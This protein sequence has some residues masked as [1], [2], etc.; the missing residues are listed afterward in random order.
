MVLHIFKEFG[1]FGCEW[2]DAEGANIQDP[3]NF[4]SNLGKHTTKESIELTT[5]AFKMAKEHLLKIDEWCCAG[6]KDPSKAMWSI[7]KGGGKQ[8][9]MWPEHLLMQGGNQSGA[10]PDVQNCR[11]SLEALTFL[12]G[13]SHGTENDDVP[14]DKSSPASSAAS[15]PAASSGHFDT[16]DFLCPLCFKSVRKLNKQVQHIKERHSFV[17][18][19][20]SRSIGLTIDAGIG[21]AEEIG[22]GTLGLCKDQ[23]GGPGPAQHLN[24]DSICGIFII[25][26]RLFSA[27]CAASFTSDLPPSPQLKLPLSTQASEEVKGDDTNDD[28]NGT[29]KGRCLLQGSKKPNLRI[30]AKRRLSFDRGSNSSGGS[31]PRSPRSPRSPSTPLIPL[32]PKSLNI[33]LKTVNH[34]CRL[35]GYPGML[36]YSHFWGLNS[37]EVMLQRSSGRFDAAG[38]NDDW[39]ESSSIGTLGTVDDLFESFP[40]LMEVPRKTQNFIEMRDSSAT[41]Y[42]ITDNSNRSSGA[43]GDCNDAKNA[44]TSN[45]NKT[46]SSKQKAAAQGSSR[47]GKHNSANEQSLA[48]SEKYPD[49][50]KC[51]ENP[52]STTSIDMSFEDYE[53]RKGSVGGSESERENGSNNEEE[54]NY[55]N[56]SIRARLIEEAFH[57]IVD[58]SLKK[59]PNAKKEKKGGGRK[60][61]TSKSS[62]GFYDGKKRIMWVVNIGDSTYNITLEHGVLSGKKTLSINGN[63]LAVKG[64]KLFDFGG[65]FK[66]RISDVSMVVSVE[67]RMSGVFKYKLMI[68]GIKDPILTSKL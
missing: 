6:K 55:R 59:D 27:H 40:F 43:G 47:R 46:K 58:P 45:K 64:K 9:F 38:I 37:S 15:S 50:V 54:L 53:S 68:E 13:P 42:L 11:E 39:T 51:V 18:S 48:K 3:V 62:W 2:S 31:S 4:S 28:K 26:K 22:G 10:N 57:K 30:D 56:K 52:M 20:F 25:T 16:H 29:L 66:F 41:P 44:V 35:A 67:S 23:K 19:F 1:N 5:E 61:S 17:F 7:G 12:I 33:S 14:S 65:K 32:F 8:N 24:L 21:R 49:N 34:A 36:L 63:L 60:G